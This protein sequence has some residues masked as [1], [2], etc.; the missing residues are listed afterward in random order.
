MKQKEKFNKAIVMSFILLLLGNF[1]SAQAQKTVTGTVFSADDNQPLPGA[2]IIIK[3]TSTGTVSDFNGKFTLNV[4]NENTTLLVSFIGFKNQEVQASQQPLNIYLEPDI[5]S[6]DEVVVVGY[7]TLKKSDIV[8]SV[9][10]V[11]MEDATTIPSTNINEMLRGRAA[12]VQVTVGSL[13]P[14]GTSNIVIRGN[15]SLAAGNN[16][17]YVVD[18]VPKDDIN[19]INPDDIT[20]IEILKDASAQ[21]IYGSRAS[22]GVV[23]VT[24]KRGKEGKVQVSYHGY[25]TVQKLSKNFDLYDGN[26]FAQLRREAYRTDNP[27]DEY[28]DDEF[29]FEPE[30]LEALKNQ[31]FVNWEDLVIENASI[32]SNTVSLNGGT[33]K[34]KVFTSINYFKQDGIIPSSGYDR[35]TFRLNLDQKITDRL[36]LAA[37]V[38]LVSSTQDKESA[39]LNLITL[40]PLAKAYDEN[41]EIIRF[42]LGSTS[43]TNPLWNIKE[44]TNEIKRNSY[45]LYLILK[46]NFAKHFNYTLNSSF[47]RRN[48]NSGLY[49]SSTHSTGRFTNGYAQLGNSLNENFLVENIIVYDNDFNENHNLNFTFVQ[50][51]DNRKYETTTTTATEFPN[52][53]L[54]YNGISAATNVLPV[55]RYAEERK[56]VSFMGRLRYNFKDKYLF[57]ATARADG[58]SVFAEGNKWGVF[59][60]AALAWKINNENFLKDVS[61]IQQLK[62]RLSYGAIG[63]EAIKPYQTLGT[64]GEF[65]YVF[66]RNPASGYLPSTVLP[67]PDLRWETTTS[68][69]AGLDFMIFKNILSGSVDYYRTSTTDLLV[70]RSVPGT[71]GYK[72]TYANAGEVQ[73]KGIEVLLTA[74]IIQNKNFRWSVTT[75]FSSNKNEIIDLYGKNEN[76]EPIDDIERGYFVGQPTKVI[77]QYDFDGIWQEGDDIAG[78]PQADQPLIGPGSIRVKDTDG[79]GAIT[80]DDRVFFDPNPDWFGSVNTTLS[81]KGLEL[82]ADFYIV[83]GVD[84]LNPYLAEYNYGGTLQGKLNGIKVPYYTPEH[85]SNSYPRPR[86][87]KADPYLYA[88]AVQDASY[89]RLRTLS[90]SYSLPRNWMSKIKIDGIQVYATGNNVFTATDYKS[91]SPEVNNNEYPDAKSFTIGVKVNF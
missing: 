11:N 89:I 39:S 67:N 49:L 61:A 31:E 60:S 90:L 86:Y 83:Q 32:Y 79:D 2:S 43:Y 48:S 55:D 33:E 46:Y 91:Y 75:T 51:T 35:G 29:I 38:S 76:G 13:R 82:F 44:S 4:D 50:S 3:G 62:L 22:N 80:G 26:E 69:N 41:G 10:K 42:P 65:L 23:L 54:G 15:K 87:S 17:I 57:T 64:A 73:N 5:A 81:F 36:S 9:A 53:L 24:T 56:L 20:S 8:S 72:T 27:N 14:G 30:E 84:K 74:N 28:E 59:P 77:Y 88:L 7:G 37:N 70:Q 63:N 40:P 58:S 1:L 25:Y 68:F 52:D 66:D 78:S 47:T 71:T 12:G 16:P 19:D 18:G 34:T 45:D 21:A 85:P 6:L